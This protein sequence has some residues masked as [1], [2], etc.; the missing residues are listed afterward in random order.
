MVKI[1]NKRLNKAH[2]LKRFLGGAINQFVN[3]EIDAEKLRAITYACS[4]QLKIIEISD[5]ESRLEKLEELEK[6]REKEKKN[7]NIKG[8]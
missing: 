2:N 6:E 3:G 1:A 8:R 4:V 5:I 7:E